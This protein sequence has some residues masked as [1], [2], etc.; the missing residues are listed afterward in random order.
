MR[1]TIPAL[2]L[3]LLLAPASAPAATPPKAGTYELAMLS[4]TGGM[5]YA[6]VK[7]TPKGD[8]LDGVLVA[9]NLPGLELKRTTLDGETLR[10][11]LNVRGG[12]LTFEGLVPQ[13]G[14]ETILGTFDPNGR[15]T[16]ARLKITD[17]TELTAANMRVPIDL[18]ES[19]RKAQTLSTKGLLLRAR[20]QRAQDADEK[21]RLLKE[22]AEA[23]KEARAEVPKLYR[24]VVE[25]HPDSPAA[26]LAA[27]NLIRQAGK[28]KDDADQVRGWAALLLKAAQPYGPR[29]EQEVTTQIA[30]LL[31]PQD[32]YAALA[33]EYAQRAEKRLTAKDSLEQQARVLSLLAMAQKKAGMAA[34]AEQTSTRLAKIETEM[35]R[36]YLA[37]M[38]PFKPETYAGRKAQSDRTVVME[39]FTGAECPPCVAADV[40]FD[41]LEK[42]YK[43]AEVV[44]IQYHLHI[45]GPDPLTSAT[46]EAR[47][48][49]YSAN[50]TPNTFFN[51]KKEAGGGGG[52]GAAENKY[53]QYCG[54]I[55]P[56]LEQPTKAAVSVGATR[57]GDTVN[58][59]AEV[60]NLAS[61]CEDTKLR[62]LL[63][64]EK[65]RFVGGNKLRFHHMV[66]RAMPGGADGV[67]LTQKDSKHTATVNLAEL[68]QE[69][70]K[71]LDDY[72]A[73]K[74]PF[75]RAGR[76]MEMKHLKVIALV[77]DDK[78]KEVIQAAV[79]E[80]GGDRAAR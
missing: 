70:G 30:E 75:P 20:A 29:Y 7:I 45:P 36:E 67:A 80:V 12:D 55:D 21:A 23:E 77:Q 54:I 41:A 9:P 38:P 61:P 28:N 5:I 1:L 2:A 50:S 72:A 74:R 13:A 46:T 31:A 19:M 62:L 65:V 43:P 32:A 18:P 16:P 26:S 14:A 71:Y 47:A 53:K 17:K 73:E 48:K 3:G 59:Q 60:S 37:K 10:I 64:E 49:Y 42:T 24:E 33:L 78:T 44:L 4:P 6:L 34:E 79:A 52:L 11:V 8:G 66:V 56:M 68:R 40:A 39:L 25:K 27:Q 51:G 69:L 58:I 22:A 57:Q 15:L 63:V 76:P 35:D